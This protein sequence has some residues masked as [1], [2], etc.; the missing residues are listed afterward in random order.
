MNTTKMVGAILIAGG[1]LGLA[2][3]GF[4]FT[5][6]THQASLGPLNLS[7]AEKETVN[8][9]LWASIVVIVAGAAVMVAGSRKG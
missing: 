9:P 2:F 5:R 3:G 4:S 7:V 8:I 6:E 1:V